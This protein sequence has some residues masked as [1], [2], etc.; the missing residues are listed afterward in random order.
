MAITDEQAEF[1]TGIV[2]SGTGRVAMAP[3]IVSLD[4]GVSLSGPDLSEAWDAASAKISA[5]QQ[6]LFDADVS[7][8]DI[9]TTRLNVHTSFDRPPDGGG[10]RQQ[11]YHLSSGVRATIR[12]LSAAESIITG[13]FNE[14]GDG[15]S[16]NG[17]TFDV[18]DQTTGRAEAIE[19]AFE[20]ARDKAV[21]LARLA[22]VSLG[23]VLSMSESASFG[24]GH[25]PVA[26]ARSVGAEMPIA[27]GELDQ[28]VT[29]TVRWAIGR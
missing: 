20:D 19:L 13:L 7:E 24:H 10:I 15:I 8:S 18:E 2:V 17:L 16:M 9:Q 5:A 1:G 12:D 14:I 3:E 27:A 4:V 28:Q 29:L 26:M 11:T 23:P 21:Q 25:A 6:C 22:G